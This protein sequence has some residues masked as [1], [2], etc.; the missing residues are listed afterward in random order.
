[1]SWKAR[2]LAPIERENDQLR[3]ELI[4]LRS[5]LETKQGTVGRLQLLVRQRSNKIDQLTATID[6][7][8]QQNRQLD[9]EAERLCEMVRLS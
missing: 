5:E 4:K 9:A 7:L 1:M 6:R 8:R 3:T 2:P